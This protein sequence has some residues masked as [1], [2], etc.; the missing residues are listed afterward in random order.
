M[1][2]LL[3]SK[4]IGSRRAVSGV[5]P[6]LAS[7]QRA[8]APPNLAVEQAAREAYAELKDQ[9]HEELFGALRG[10][11][12]KRMTG[13]ELQT[14]WRSSIRSA[15]TSAFA[16]GNQAEGYIGG[17]ETQ[18][19]SWLKGAWGEEYGFLGKFVRA[20]ESDTL[21]MPADD[22][23]GMY[24]ETLDGI[25]NA[26]RVDALPEN[27]KIHWRLHPADHCSTCVGMAFGGPYGK[28]G[29]SDNPLTRVPRD[30]STICLTGCKCSLE[31]EEI[32]PEAMG[33]RVLQKRIPGAAGEGRPP[34]GFRD[35]N[36]AERA[37][38]DNL[39]SRI[40]FS[41]QA[42]VDLMGDA[43]KHEI[44][45]RQRLADTLTN[46]LV[47][48]KLWVNPSWTSGLYLSPVVEEAKLAELM[49]G[50]ITAEGVAALIAL[51]P[52][53]YLT[54][55]DKYE[56]SVLEKLAL[57]TASPELQQAATSMADLLTLSLAGALAVVLG[58]KKKAKPVVP[59][60]ERPAQEEVTG[61]PGGLIQEDV[62]TSSLV[63][64]ALKPNMWVK[65]R[66]KKWKVIG[67]YE[68][69]L[70][71]HEELPSTSGT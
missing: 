49:A 66:G 2:L 55:M 48:Q 43:K 46:F 69:K 17:L 54:L 40:A 36:E 37:F 51:S 50:S 6:I 38:I 15:W 44:L 58:K 47:T 5:K 31:V 14:T 28:P 19:F 62:S 30:G 39:I 63:A 53:A 18:D 42:I 7:A 56:A 1:T 59:A 60:E 41:R 23:L 27:V 35:P 57:V 13:A 32:P 33:S 24:V 10:Y 52:T 45:V 21:K 20:L 65:W 64:P 71:S 9:F 22:R 3:E 61:T 25:F 12:A 26:G 34:M 16:L 70:A 11:Q 8:L 4:S 29:S 68:V 67:R